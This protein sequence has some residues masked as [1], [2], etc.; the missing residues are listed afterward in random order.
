VLVLPEGNRA[1][2]LHVAPGAVCALTAPYVERV[3]VILSAGLGVVDAR[4]AVVAAGVDCPA[5]ERVSG[6]G[7]L[8]V[9]AAHDPAIAA[10]NKH[11]LKRPSFLIHAP[12]YR[13]L[14]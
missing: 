10:R 2:A 4:C 12:E 5:S 6:F 13:A 9:A 14:A 7:G 3:T 8:S 1:D 11:E